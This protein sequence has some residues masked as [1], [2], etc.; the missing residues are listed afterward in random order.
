M[1]IIKEKQK[2]NDIH[3]FSD[4]FLYHYTDEAGYSGWFDPPKRF[5]YHYTDQPGL[6]L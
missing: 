3:L 6:S 5:Y 2:H 1:D 4:L